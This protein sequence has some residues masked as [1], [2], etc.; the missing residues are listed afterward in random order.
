MQFS[1][2]SCFLI[3]PPLK[4]IIALSIGGVWV[5][6]RNDN[7]TIRKNTMILYIALGLSLVISA[8]ISPLLTLCMEGGMSAVG[9][10]FYRVL[11][12]AA[13]LLPPTLFSKKHRRSLVE[14]AVADRWRLAV[15]SFTKAV[16]FLIWAE[17]LRLGATAFTTSA[18]S[19]MTPVFVV[20][21]SYFV[22]KQR[23][24]LKALVGIAVCLVGVCVISYENIG[25][26]G[27]PVAVALIAVSCL[28]NSVNV[29]VGKRLRES[30][31]FVPL[32]GVS[33]LLSAVFLWGYATFGRVAL[34]IPPSAVLPLLFLSFG[35]T[36]FGHSLSVWVL[37]F[38][39]PVTVSVSGLVSP[40]LTALAA[41][42]LLEEVPTVMMYVG[43]A[44]MSVG[45][46]CYAVAVGENGESGKRRG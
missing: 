33:Y 35:S 2:M 23:T 40:F 45:L 1:T 21:I 18:L 16:G 37:G 38:L 10:T 28:G 42:L 46:F 24:P 43:A 5:D 32:M 30:V 7:N 34:D 27:S 12:V 44:V 22:L 3:I 36:L 19:Q 8:F 15:Y 11:F 39:R 25:N 20:A 6:K 26:V 9:A 31:E 4:G 13:V 41:F 29:L 17:A 14:M